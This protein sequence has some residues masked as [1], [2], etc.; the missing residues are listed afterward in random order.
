MVNLVRIC[1][2]TDMRQKD[3]HEVQRAY[4][5]PRC[6]VEVR[7]KHDPIS[8]RRYCPHCNYILP[9]RVAHFELRHMIGTGG[10]GTVYLGHDI[11]LERDVAVKMM[12]EEFSKKPQFVESFLREARA[13]AAL[14]HPNVAQIYSFG[15][16]DSSYYLV[17]ELLSGG[18]LD[19]RLEKE[20]RLSE[21][22]VLDIGIQIASGLRI[23][24]EHGLIH[25]DIK[26]GN[27]LFAQD[28]TA[29]VVDFGLAQFEDKD[30]NSKEHKVEGIWGTPYYLA[31]E[32]V[33]NDVEDFRSDIYSLGGTL[34]HALAGRAPFEA[35]TSTEIVLK[36]LHSP[37]VSLRAFVPDCTPQ[38]A[39][40]IGR[41]LKRDPADRHQSY[42]ELLNDLAYAK[43][44]ALQKKP[45]EK[46]EVESDFSISTLIWTVAL[47]VACAG[48]A[49][50][51]WFNRGKFIGE[52]D[53]PPPASENP[54]VSNHSP[55]DENSPSPSPGQ[56]TPS[57]TP[58]PSNDTLQRE[59]DLQK[60]KEIEKIH[61]LAGRDYEHLNRSVPEF[62]RIQKELR[63]DHPLQLWL[64]LSIARIKWL[65]GY[66][67][68]AE[69]A[70]KNL[71]GSMDSVESPI[72][73]TQY[74]QVL[75][76]VLKGKL[77][78]EDLKKTISNLPDWM[79]ACAL[80]DA[81]SALIQ[82]NKLSEAAAI[83][84]EY[85]QIKNVT[86][87]S[88][89]LVYQPMARDFISEFDWL[90]KVKER[91]EEFKTAG[92][93]EEI[94]KIL[95][96]NQPRWH[97]PAILNNIKELKEANDV[98]IQ[99]KKE[100]DDKRKVEEK[101]RLVAAEI[102]LM[103]AVRA[104]KPNLLNDYQFNQLVEAWKALG[105]QIHTDENPKILQRQIAIAQ[106]LADYKTNLAKDIAKLPYD[107]GK[108]ITRKGSEIAGKLY[109]MKDDKLLFKLEGAETAY[110]LKQ[111]APSTILKLGD[112]YFL[113][114]QEAKE[115]ALELARRAIALATFAR[116]YTLPLSEIQ[117]YLSFADK[118]GA[119]IKD[120]LENLEFI[121]PP[122]R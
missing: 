12:R 120:I 17:M 43:R 53:V 71:I 101:S 52:T 60:E 74:P 4:P 54:T 73:E 57:P 94:Q 81:G 68:E 64:K 26:P 99:R 32:K 33:T 83:W 79:R 20:R 107:K 104:Q 23:A 36:H 75:A 55:P 44:F 85:D 116:E 29:K 15:E 45:A 88:W 76:F 49:V 3:T 24:C 65:T 78:G 84:K 39:E 2:K 40:V 11:S 111:L 21:I 61:N 122:P 82:Q 31:P 66:Y 95:Q 7:F 28:G 56:P 113:R 27:I 48:F 109:L 89:V 19:D 70:L 46:V 30:K 16:Q 110:S 50:W 93:F 72:P 37:T 115:P 100:D 47:I 67:P 108:F 119:D 121:V 103:D 6:G 22:E 62:E 86:T 9:S 14:N 41:M 18:S 118:S 42:D 38:T 112:F 97:T 102:K 106:W 80:F 5:C 35:D 34:Y 13:A 96:D 117:K 10:M 92:K 77:S 51:L 91:I 1:Y 59:K 58:P 105:S 69:E 25:R 98:T 63:E 8:G 90:N 87:H 114:A